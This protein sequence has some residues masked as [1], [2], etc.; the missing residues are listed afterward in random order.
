M[1]NINVTKH[2]VLKWPAASRSLRVR[3]SS[4]VSTTDVVFNV[5]STSD[6]TGKIALLYSFDASLTSRDRIALLQAQLLVAVED[7]ASGRVTHVLIPGGP[8]HP[9]LRLELD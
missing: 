2:A 5:G 8:G 7:I 1:N 9:D 4:G 3:F 6:L